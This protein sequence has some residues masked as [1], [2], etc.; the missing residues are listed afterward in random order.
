MIMV[1]I[2]AVGMSITAVV[3]ANMYLLTNASANEAFP[4]LKRDVF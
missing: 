1:V 3:G 2:M 4:F